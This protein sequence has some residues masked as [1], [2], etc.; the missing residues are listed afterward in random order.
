[1]DFFSLIRSQE[2]L[3]AFLTQSMSFVVMLFCVLLFARS[4][5]RCKAFH[6]R[7]FASL[8]ITVGIFATVA[9]LR[10]RFPSIYTR[11]GG[12]FV[13]YFI[14]LPLLFLCYQDTRVN[15]LLTWCAGVAAQEVAARGFAFVL[16]I[17]NVDSQKSISF[18]PEAYLPRDAFI[19]YAANFLLG[20]LAYRA[21][22]ANKCVDADRTSMRTTTSLSVFSALWM[23]LSNSI[24]REFQS[25]SEILYL[26]L[27]AFA[28]VFAGFVLYLR[29]GIL[30]Q[31]EYRNEITLMEQLLRQE[32]KQYQN[33]KENR[34]IINMM[35]HDLKH[36]L[37][38]LSAKL[39]AQEIQTIQQAICIYDN[40]IKTGSEV[41]DV[42]IYEKQLICQ[43]E[44]VSFSCMADGKA[45]SFMRTT[46]IYALFDNALENA[47][48]AVRKL[49]D[50]EMRVVNLSVTQNTDVVEILVSN[51]FRGELPLRDGLPLTTTKDDKNRH[52]FG[53]LSMKYVA[54]LYGGTLAA[55]V[56]GSIFT[57]S[58]SIPIQK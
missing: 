42:L 10:L 2:F 25:E 16:T 45:L 11:I 48:E 57:L 1:M 28:L 40:N 44:G 29:T 7:L 5:R 35:Y 15:I 22:S 58:I 31:S 27:Q 37:S 13:S 34:D 55:A 20:Y 41:L 47:L 18:F 33:A 39:T 46:H 30:V 6:L 17:F 26:F 36:Q 51:Y 52:G 21:F 23:A 3:Q 4:L 24:T 49:D 12:N 8:L 50:S 54:E 14:A 53:T 19:M 32:R 38:S 56:K 9:L 43:K